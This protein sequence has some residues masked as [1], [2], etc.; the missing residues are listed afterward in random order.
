MRARDSIFEG[1]PQTGASRH[2]VGDYEIDLLE[3]GLRVLLSDVDENDWNYF[4]WCDPEPGP[5]PH[6]RTCSCYA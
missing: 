6:C 4:D 2:L 1:C 5:E 3:R